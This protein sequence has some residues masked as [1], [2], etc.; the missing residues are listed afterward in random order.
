MS[1]LAVMDILLES[2]EHTAERAHLLIGL[3]EQVQY[4]SECSLTAYAG[5]FGKLSHRPLERR[6]RIFSIHS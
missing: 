3:G 5:E 4:Q 2:G 1:L 6:R